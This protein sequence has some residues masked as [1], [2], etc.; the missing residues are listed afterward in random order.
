M[1]LYCGPLYQQQNAGIFDTPA[2][3][4]DELQ[5]ILSRVWANFI[6]VQREVSC[7]NFTMHVEHEGSSSNDAKGHVA[8]NRNM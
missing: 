6:L 8:L 3:A 2:T 1:F 4:W 5:G 7:M